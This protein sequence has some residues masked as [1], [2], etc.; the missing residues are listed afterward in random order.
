LSKTSVSRFL[1]VSIT[2]SSS[3]AHGG[4][5]NAGPFFFFL[6]GGAF[7]GSGF[8]GALAPFFGGAGSGSGY[9]RYG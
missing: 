5:G 8:G 1:I 3:N 4:V 9:S 2:A 6:G 7:L